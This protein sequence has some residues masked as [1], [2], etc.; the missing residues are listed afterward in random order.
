MICLKESLMLASCDNV[1]LIA[2]NINKTIQNEIE[3]LPAD[4][5]LV[6]YG[7]MSVYCALAKDI[8]IIMNEIGCIRHKLFQHITKEADDN[9]DIDKFDSTYHHLF[10]WHNVE[11]EIVGAYRLGLTKHI[12]SKENS[13]GL[14]MQ[15][16]FDIKPDF[17]AELGPMIEMGRTFIVEKYQ[18]S[19]TPL[20]LLWKGIGKIATRDPEYRHLFGPV[21]VP[22]EF[23]LD[24]K[25]AIIHYLTN[26]VGLLPQHCYVKPKL[27]P[28]AYQENLEQYNHIQ[29]IH[30]LSD[31]VH[32]KESGQRVLPVLIREYLKMH[33]RY[34]ACS[35]DANFGDCLDLFFIADLALSDPRKLNRYMGDEAGDFLRFHHGDEKPVTN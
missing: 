29:T 13:T 15:E 33:T 7:E 20:L 9:I 30:E 6:S 27:L 10:I 1:T 11:H 12:F 22:S 31:Y 4:A 14:Y 18:R 25:K 19:Y 2:D 34:I 16:L 17:F 24:S 35:I 21:S 28:S 32:E 23:S 5:L 8:P 26:H 3:S